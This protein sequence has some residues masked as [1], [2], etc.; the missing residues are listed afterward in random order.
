M[1]QGHQGWPSA[2]SR[3]GQ[4]NSQHQHL[5]RTRCHVRLHRIGANRLRHQPQNYLPL[6]FQRYLDFEC[7]AQ[8]RRLC[9]ALGR[10]FHH[11][12]PRGY[13]RGPSDR[14]GSR[15]RQRSDVCIRTSADR[16]H[17]RHRNSAQ[18]RARSG[19]VPLSRSVHDAGGSRLQSGF[20]T[21]P[22]RSVL[23]PGP[24]NIRR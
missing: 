8:R 18:W 19:A 5:R 20:G 3:K 16:R 6:C 2:L 9:R 24:P 12:H 15:R 13:R 17:H 4:S 7:R 10:R 22:L 21:S 11:L 23:L 14:P 1:W